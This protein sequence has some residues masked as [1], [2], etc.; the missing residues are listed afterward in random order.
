MV[1]RIQM[2]G[3]GGEG[4]SDVFVDRSMTPTSRFEREGGLVHS[5]GCSFR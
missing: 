5:R 4:L 3:D 1:F 2:A